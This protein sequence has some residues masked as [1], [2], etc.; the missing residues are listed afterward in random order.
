[1][2]RL[3]QVIIFIL[4]ILAFVYLGTRDYKTN[5]KKKIDS[6]IT[7]DVLIK[8]DTVFIDTNHSKILSKLSSKSSFIIYACIDDNKLCSK[9]GMLIDE[10]AK[11]YEISDIYYYDF[12]SI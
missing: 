12:K 10:I 7:S 9:Y 3:I 1:M 2:K 11:N 8:D 4:L 5:K 6:N